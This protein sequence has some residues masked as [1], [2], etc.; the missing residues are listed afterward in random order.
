MAGLKLERKH[1]RPAEEEDEEGEPAPP[2]DLGLKTTA[3]GD[4]VIVSTVLAGMPAY[5]AGINS[6]D[7][8][9][10]INGERVTATSLADRL[11]ALKPRA[12]VTV[13]V[14]RREQLMTFK[15][16]TVEKLPDRYAISPAKDPTPE[17]RA[18]YRSWVGEEMQIEK[19]GGPESQKR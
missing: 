2:G 11:N 7:E 14:F 5:T 6:G 18:L 12:A 16:T 1:R 17:Q 19:A 8:I 9:V 13:T 4:R 10:A 15:F 3:A